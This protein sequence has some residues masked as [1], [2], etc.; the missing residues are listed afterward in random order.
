MTVPKTNM[1]LKK[2]NIPFTMV[3]NEILSRKDI[4]FKAKG[5]YAY[6]FSKPEGWDFSSSRIKNESSD[7]RD[8][9]LSGLRELEEKGLLQRIKYPD[10]RMEYVLIFSES[11][12]RESRHRLEDPESGFPS[13]G[14][15]ESG[16]SR[17]ISNKDIDTKKEKE[18]NKDI[19]ETSSAE[20]FS[21]KEELTKMMENPRREIK[22]IAWFI[23]KKDIPLKNKQQVST[24]IS[25]HVIAAKALIPFDA[26]QIASAAFQAERDMPQK[27]TLETILKYLTK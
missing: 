5:M 27:W 19:A 6:L 3:A 11:Q 15:A 14:K 26:K 1:R 7:G 12:S 20:A 23:N 22:I 13:V 18:S 8:S 4:S 25:R 2:Q 10:G 17:P 21:L 16:K 24:T 9:T